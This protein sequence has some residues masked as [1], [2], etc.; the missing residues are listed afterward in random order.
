MKLSALRP[1]PLA[2]A[3]RALP[4]TERIDVIVDTLS[5]A[6]KPNPTSWARLAVTLAMRRAST[7]GHLF[8]SGARA[9]VS[10]YGIVLKHPTLP[11]DVVYI[12][13][14]KRTDRDDQHGEAPRA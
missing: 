4:D 14:P 7:N 8:V 12:K 11:D 2:D 1:M 6:C 13:T 9:Q 3:L 5:G 10:G